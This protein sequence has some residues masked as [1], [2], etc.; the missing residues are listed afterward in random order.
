MNEKKLFDTVAQN[1]VN[2]D[3]TSESKIINLSARYLSL[4]MDLETETDELYRQYLKDAMAQIDM[5]IDKLK[6]AC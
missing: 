2:S 3:A 6:S 5:Q 4:E 1:I